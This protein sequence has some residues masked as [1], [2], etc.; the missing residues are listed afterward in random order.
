MI[1]K[2][3]MPF[4]KCNFRVLTNASKNNLCTKC[5][6]Y[7]QLHQKIGEMNIYFSS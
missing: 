6:K 7:S 2:L 1:R 4:L 3:Q 5:Y